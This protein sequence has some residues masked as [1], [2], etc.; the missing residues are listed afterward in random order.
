MGYYNIR[1]YP[2]SQEMTAIVT[3]Y[4]KFRYNCLHM[5]MCASGHIFQAKVDKLRSD[6]EGFKTYLDYILVLIKDFLIKHI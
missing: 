4:G 2:D 1:L 6:I 5:G 3:E